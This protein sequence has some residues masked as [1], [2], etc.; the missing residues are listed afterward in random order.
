LKSRGTQNSANPLFALQSPVKELTGF[1][2]FTATAAL[3]RLSPEYFGLTMLY[4]AT[5]KPL[6]E[7]RETDRKI[8]SSSGKK[9]G[10]TALFHELL[11]TRANGTKISDEI[12]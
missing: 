1:P 10:R 11:I 9:N 6:Q 5:Y 7:M 3:R 2:E 4:A 8:R 12:I